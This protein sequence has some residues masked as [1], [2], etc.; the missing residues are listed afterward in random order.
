MRFIISDECLTYKPAAK[1]GGF[2]F[3]KR[4]YHCL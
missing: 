4:L 1:A 3:S 2:S